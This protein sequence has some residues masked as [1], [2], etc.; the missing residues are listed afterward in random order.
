LGGLRLDS[1]CFDFGGK[2]SWS[3][4]FR[5]RCPAADA[6]FGKPS[7]RPVQE[8]ASAVVGVSYS[9]KRARRGVVIVSVSGEIDAYS[10]PKLRGGIRAAMTE[11]DTKQVQVDL[12]DVS[13]M[14]S[15]G[16]NALIRCRAEAGP[17]GILLVV[18]NPQP[19]PLKVLD[20]LGLIHV[21]GVTTDSGPLSDAET[22]RGPFLLTNPPPLRGPLGS[23]P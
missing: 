7:A 12:A 1:P 14:D 6:E 16:V 19:E 13:F 8:R 17:R 18:A 3:M 20:I 5:G 22:D 15:Y 11:P 23:V 21:L 2:I 10:A 4:T 9:T